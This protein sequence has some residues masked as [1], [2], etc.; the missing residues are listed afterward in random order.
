MEAPAPPFVAPDYSAAD[1]CRLAPR[2][3]LRLA[4]WELGEA[5]LHLL[6]IPLVA[7]IIWL[8]H[9]RGSVAEL[10]FGTFCTAVC[11]E[12]DRQ[13]MFALR[14]RYPNYQST[15]IR[16]SLQ[17]LLILAYTLLVNVGMAA[18][19]SWVFMPE[20]QYGQSY[21]SC[22]LHSLPATA[23]VLLIYESVYF[24]Q[25]WKRYYLRTAWLEK[26]RA[27]SQLAALKQQV[28]PHFLF[29]T[30][31]TLAALVGDNE[32]AQEFLDELANVYRY[33]LSRRDQATV[34]L[35]EEMA[36]VE[37]YVYLNKIRHQ[38]AV[39]VLSQ[40]PAAV[41]QQ[42]VPPLSVQMLVEN[43]IKHNAASPQRPLRIEL[44]EA[45]GYVQVS[46]NVQPK[47]QLARGARLGLRNL[48]E[49]FQLLAGREVLVEQDAGRFAVKLPLLT[50]A[51]A[52]RT[53]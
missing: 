11:W 20:L 38:E 31:N 6:G 53:H 36:F 48:Q 8:L 28:D 34:T 42:H 4:K 46:N 27:V 13:I 25:E 12:G 17:A 19:R 7:L 41:L 5:Q 18:V 33:V 9:S 52:R 40:L 37:S 35:A 3:W 24:F 30:L 1:T 47:T 39:Q 22:L 49:Q 32:P 10:A 43:A 14:R 23:I 26:E 29:N 21:A 45:A 2:T 15:L 51:H 16:L 50:P 44:C